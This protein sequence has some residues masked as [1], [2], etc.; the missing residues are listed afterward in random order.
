MPHSL[1]KQ[2]KQF[3]SET[4]FDGILITRFDSFL[5]EYFPPDVTCL[6]DVTGGFSGSAGL[7]LITQDDNILFVD[8]RYTLQAKKQTFFKVFEVPSETTPSAWIKQHLK[9]KKIAFDPRKHSVTWY[10]QFSQMLSS[11][12]IELSPLSKEETEKLFPQKQFIQIDVFDYDVQYS[13]QSVSDKKNEI[14]K[15]LQKDNLDCFVI[16][17]PENVSWLLNKRAGTV[18]EYPVVFEQGIIDIYGH[19]EPLNIKRLSHLK[20]KRIGVDLS[21]T[22][23]ALYDTIKLFAEIV[24]VQDPIN[25]LKAIKN[26]IEIANIKQAC[27]S[28]SKTICRFLSWIELNKSHITEMQCDFYLKQLR[29]EDKLYFA[30]SFETIAAV[31][32]H[33]AR[34]HYRADESSDTLITTSALLLVDTGGHYLNGTTDMTRTI[35]IG[36]PS[37]MMKK[38]YTQVLQGH[39]DL[40]MSSL[41]VTDTTAEMDKKAHHWLRLDNVDYYHGTSHGIGMFLAVHETPPVVHERD[42]HGMIS[43]M[44]FSNEP[45]YYDSEAGYGIRLENMLLSVQ[46]DDETLVF[47]NLLFI[48][49]DYRLVLFDMLTQEQKNWLKHY[50]KQIEERIFP[51]LDAETKKILKPFVDAFQ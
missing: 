32:E 46:Q 20:G 31:G 5:G 16:T 37:D 38:R 27:L 49:F 12:Q 17:S 36:Q 1:Y 14:V 51:L 47:E 33:A 6:K 21:Q 29:C 23:Y 8:S 15:F 13:G 10:L 40:A 41:K 34:A 39:I 42:T 43:G 25:K 48:P 7:A 24:P 28:E 9:G 50:H 44:V 35:A 3:I 19:Y 30:D 4:D 18:S 2:I 22:S 45:A 11:E 26:K